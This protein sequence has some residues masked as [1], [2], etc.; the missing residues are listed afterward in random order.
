MKFT[1]NIQV[2]ELKS[3]LNYDCETGIFT[4]KVKA[5]YRI[6][7]GEVAGTTHANGYISIRL[8]GVP[9]KAHRLA[10]LYVYGSWP[11]DQIDHINGCRNDNRIINLRMASN[12]ENCRNQGI[13]KRNTSG[14]RGV[15]F[16][17]NNG[18]WHAYMGLNKKT[19][20]LGFY[21]KIEDAISAR[22]KAENLYFGEF[23]PKQLMGGN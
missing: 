16:N 12:Q 1:K 2:E 8:H 4:W 3:R 19:I 5:S 23:S 21:Q 18:K 20:H 17:K 15:G 7:P 6:N 22:N 11:D 13:S 9:Y 10:W 14:Y